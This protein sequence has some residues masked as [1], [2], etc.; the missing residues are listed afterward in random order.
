MQVGRTIAV[1]TNIDSLLT[2]IAQQIQQAL[3][4]DRCTVFLLDD[5]N[6]RFWVI[7]LINIDLNHNIDFNQLWAE[8]YHIYHKQ[9]I[10]NYWLTPEE[11]EI[12]EK[13]NQNYKFKGELETL[14]DNSFDFMYNKRIWLTSS[15]VAQIVGGKH[16]STKITRCLKSMGIEQKNINNKD[17]PRGRYNSMP[18]P[19]MWGKDI[20][21]RY[22]KRIVSPLSEVKN[23]DEKD[24]LL[25]DQQEEIKNLK[26]HIRYL[27]N[28]LSQV[29]T[30]L[31]IM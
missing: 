28:K 10:K 2:I 19:V 17:I 16:G 21:H 3:Q 23:L 15:E 30:Q 20:P 26:Q 11:Q 12:I 25:Q 18:I 29:Y 7:E 8:M 13:N 5:E 6:R 22:V 9:N 14:I 31:E 24:K 27:E 1:E 4:A